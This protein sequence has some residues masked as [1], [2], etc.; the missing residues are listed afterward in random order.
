[1]TDKQPPALAT[2][3]VKRAARGNEALVGD[4]VEEFH[5]G[6]SAVWYWRQALT[7]VFADRAKPLAWTLG[8][9]A[10]YIIGSYI[11]IPGANADLPA[12]L[13]RRAVGA[14]FR[15]FSVVFGGQLTGITIFALGI[16]PYLSAAFIVQAVA[17]LCRF[18]R[19][20][21][22]RQ[23]PMPIVA[24]TWC[25]ATLLCTTQAAGVAAF[26]ERSSL[27]NSGLPPIVINPGWA[28]RITT[29]LTLTAGTT[30]LML[31]SDQISKRRIGNGMLLVFGA[32]LAAGVAGALGPLLAGQIDPFAVLIA[33]ALNTLVAAVVS[34]GYRRAIERELAP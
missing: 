8:V 5:R 33:L 3:L 22:Q 28:F 29:L 18:L 19:P 12:L 16:G 17:L 34:H 21:S 10:L 4:L 7:A 2:W 26:L 13:E 9:V 31:I 11:S 30:I 6:R 23:R 15:L 14:P 20:P 24:I 27:A 1:M 32:G 25:V